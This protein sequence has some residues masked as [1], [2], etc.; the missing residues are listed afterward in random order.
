MGRT[1]RN[2]VEGGSC[3]PEVVFSWELLRASAAKGQEAGGRESGLNEVKDRRTTGWQTL[4]WSAHYNAS[5]AAC[6]L[7]P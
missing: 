6:R 4:I 5:G 2:A 1:L 3:L 7:V